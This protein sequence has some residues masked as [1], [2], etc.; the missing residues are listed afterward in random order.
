MIEITLGQNKQLPTIKGADEIQVTTYLAV[1]PLQTHH[2]ILKPGET[3]TALKI[4]VPGACS[5]EFYNVITP[6]LID[7][8]T[9]NC[10][11]FSGPGYAW[12]VSGAA[13]DRSGEPVTGWLLQGGSGYELSFT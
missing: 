4:F 12:L 11:V 2:P 7:G 5:V 1:P 10:L 9:V 6:E 3:E 8:E 13:Q